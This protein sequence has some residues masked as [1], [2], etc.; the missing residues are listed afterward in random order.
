MRLIGMMLARNE[1]WVMGLSARVALEWCDELVIVDH[2]STDLTPRIISEL[3]GQYAWRVNRS[4]WDDAEKWDEMEMRDHALALA[5]KFGGT[6]AA[7]IDADEIL[8]G[9]L[10]YS[11]RD[12]VE[13]LKPGECLELPMIAAWRNLNQYRD[14]ASDW[15]RAWIS[16]AFPVTETLT[17]KPADDGYQF[18]QRK[19]HGISS[20][21][22]PLADKREGGVMHLQFANWERLVAKH[23]HYRMVEQIRW[24]GRMSAQELNRKYDNAL[25]EQDLQVKACDPAWT[26]RYHAWVQKHLRLGGT[27]WYKA[28]VARMVAF[29]GKAAFSGL[30]LKGIA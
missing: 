18:H 20:T 7:I 1:D 29:H 15:S 6:H 5:R 27:P 23:V 3:N 25:N 2:A 10:I 12:W 8:T 16:L 24:P 26:A 17:Y 30:D 21:L 11:V 4:R 13:R 19:P 14:D 22:R 9:N 28:E